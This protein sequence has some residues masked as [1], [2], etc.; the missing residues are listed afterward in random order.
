MDEYIDLTEEPYVLYSQDGDYVLS[1]EEM[2]ELDELIKRIK[3]K[4]VS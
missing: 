1:P 3:A 4:A 2:K